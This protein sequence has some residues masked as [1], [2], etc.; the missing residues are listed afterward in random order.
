MLD[1]TV[2]TKL[3]NRSPPSL[4]RV[5]LKTSHSNVEPGAAARTPDH[6]TG[7]A[8]DHTVVRLDSGHHRRP[9]VVLHDVD[10]QGAVGLRSHGLLRQKHYER[11]QGRKR[12]LPERWL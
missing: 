3:I 12:S 9:A 1:F 4:Q 2:I 11:S 6:D 10:I 7:K 8:L 5:Q